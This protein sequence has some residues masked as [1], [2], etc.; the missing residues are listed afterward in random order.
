[1]QSRSGFMGALHFIADWVMRLSIVNLL[2]FT[3]NIPVLSIVFFMVI[4]PSVSERLLLGIPLFILLILLFFP[5]T[6]AVFAVARDWVMKT[7]TASLWKKFWK[8]FTSNY[9]NALVIGLILTIIWGVWIADL[10]YFNQ[11]NEIFGVVFAI[12]GVL[13]FAFTMIYLSIY[14][15]YDMGKR[16]QLKNA[17]FVT[18]GSPLLTLLILFLHLIIAYLTLRFWF[19]AVFFTMSL[20]AA[21]TFYLFYR[22]TLKVK[23]KTE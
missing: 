14:V 7:E 21:V 3:I 15:H 6:V 4:S 2:W 12:L 10:Y 20:S 19:T 16:A 5:S 1:M 17:F 18:A 11:V 23:E 8:H 9:K 13:L 22:F